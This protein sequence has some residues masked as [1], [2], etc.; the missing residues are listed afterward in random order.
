MRFIAE[1]SEALR[2]YQQA[3]VL[4]ERQG[5][6]ESS[7]HV[8][9]SLLHASHPAHALLA[10][11]K[12]DADLVTLLLRGKHAVAAEPSGVVPRLK[13]RARHIARGTET[14]QVD[15]LH[16]LIAMTRLRDSQAYRILQRAGVSLADLR[17]TAISFATGKVPRRYRAQ[18]MPPAPPPPLLLQPR[19]PCTEAMLPK[20]HAA[21]NA[22]GKPPGR[23]P[24]APASPPSPTARRPAA[25]VPAPANHDRPAP[26]DALE[27]HG[28][29]PPEEVGDTLESLAPTLALCGTD[30]TAHARLGLLDCAIGRDREVEALIDIL[31]KRRANNPV[32]VG[33]AGV[34][35]TAIVEGLA[36]KIAR[37]DADVAHF[38]DKILVALD[39]GALVA[40]TSLRG[41]FSE[42]LGAIKAEVA[43]AERRIIV[44]ID[45]MHTLMG[46]GT[47][48]EGPQD[49]A[50][51]LKAALARG[52]FPC[53][54]ATTGDE[55]RKY[56]EKDA[57]LER[58]F[59]PVFVEEPTCEE[60]LL[61]LKGAAGPYAEHHNLDFTLEAMHAAVHLSHRFITERKLPDKAFAIIDLAGSRA[62]RRQSQR[63]ERVDVARV[64]H[65]WSGVPMERLEEADAMRL[66][67]LEAAISRQ[68][69]GHQDIIGQ[70]AAAVRRGFAGLNGLRPMASLLL[71][72][73]TG[74]G[75]TEL[76][77]VLSECLYGRRDAMVRFDMSELAEKHAISRLVGAQPGYVGYEEGGQLTEAL[78]KRPFQVVLFD[79][80][81]KAH[82]D[83]LN[84]LLQL[85]D[86]GVLTD[87][88]GRR[89]SFANTVV[90]L[91]S[92]A[93][94]DRM[95]QGAG[96]VGFS[97]AASGTSQDARLTQEVLQ[98]AQK[99]L[100]AELWSRL[101]ER[102]VFHPLDRGQVFCIAAMQLEAC[103]AQLKSER[104]VVLHWD[105]AVVNFLCKI[106]VGACGARHVRQNIVRHVQAPIADLIVAGQLKSSERV[107][108]S[109]SSC[110]NSLVV[111]RTC[112]PRR[113]RSAG[114]DMPRV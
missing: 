30:L 2:T 108:L 24:Q 96:V 87:S 47:S 51:E 14:D 54:G 69:V 11:Q 53:I 80:I 63:V 79:E 107:G 37:G 35:K 5:Q 61:I 21:Q 44:F 103:A 68:I 74:V 45:E 82:A 66:G 110:G 32:L 113:T 48:G 99:K 43:R 106:G 71:L 7:A 23:L 55:F 90:V 31:G 75:K 93:G 6:R 59:T 102:L 28:E 33:P 3:A 12:V 95:T 97:Q 20:T 27:A 88:R 78:R 84:L 13:E 100:N 76:V 98:T 73:P 112:A 89:I 81:E 49:A 105:D 8:L 34:G 57:A 29:P 17:S 15:C 91:T 101:D 40:G 86:E 67:G 56:I 46:A 52:E 19:K 16:I 39:T 83:V 1:S 25:A 72:G 58:R 26:P 94:C 104:Q 109:L 65:E 70:V 50:N 38:Q 41:A 4:A 64:V 85:L 60:A 10:A 92:N 42:R 62:R 9:L 114:E 36:V 111:S 77:K 18:P 22:T